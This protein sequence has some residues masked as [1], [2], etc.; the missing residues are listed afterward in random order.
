M[1]AISLFWDINM[2][3]VTSVKTIYSVFQHDFSHGSLQRIL[4]N[5][6]VPCSQFS[7]GI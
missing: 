5:R 3:A 7:V 2:A 4:G 6:F 1:A